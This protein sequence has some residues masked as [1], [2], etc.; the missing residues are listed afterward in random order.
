MR[1]YVLFFAVALS[2]CVG[3]CSQ[4][5]KDRLRGK[6]AGQSVEN[7]E[8]PHKSEA[9]EWAK[10]VRF[11]FDDA[12]MTVTIPSE[13]PRSGKYQVEKSSGDRFTIR[14]AREMGSTDST[15]VRFKG[16]KLLWEVGEGR[17]VVMKRVD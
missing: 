11:E 3:G 6:W 1:K 14:V 16:S 10:G 2:L 9:S 5:P 8:E 17:D 12:N 4:N 7:V 13:T 15:T